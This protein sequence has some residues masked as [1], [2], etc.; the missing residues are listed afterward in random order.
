[1]SPCLPRC[2]PRPG[3]YQDTISAWRL[4]QTCVIRGHKHYININPDW[5]SFDLLLILMVS[6]VHYAT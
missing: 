1:M 4:L 6:S 5:S 2:P 3:L